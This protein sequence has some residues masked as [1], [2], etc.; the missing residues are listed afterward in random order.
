MFLKKNSQYNNV[1]YKF[2][3]TA[4]GAEPIKSQNLAG[5]THEEKCLTH[6]EK[7]LTHVEECLTHVEKCLTH[8]EKCL[9]HVEKCL[10]HVE[11]CLTE[12][13]HQLEAPAMATTIPSS[14]TVI[15]KQLSKLS[16]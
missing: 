1:K 15:L 11:T 3:T 6:V 10:I 9:T 5:L 4:S 2:Q 12:G 7:C 16:V 13:D 14:I 8:V